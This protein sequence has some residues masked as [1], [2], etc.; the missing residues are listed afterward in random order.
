MSWNYCII[1]IFCVSVSESWP[2]ADPEPVLYGEV[3]SPQYPNPYPPNLQKQWDL[4]V[5]EGYQISLTFT[6]LDIEASV[7]CYYDS[8]TVLHDEKVLGKFCGQNSTDGHHPGHQPILSPSNKLTLVLQTDQ[9]NPERHQNIGFRAHYQ[10]IDI[11]E[12]SAP[13]PADGSGPLCSQICLN[14]LGSYICSCHHGYELRHDQRT[15][16]LSCVGGIFDDLEGHISS[17]GYPNAPPHAVSCQYIISV[18]QGFQ[19][20][21]NFSDNFN[22]ESMETEEGTSCHHHWLQ[23]TIENKE[24]MKLCGK[25]S[26]G[27][28][29][30]NSNIVKLDYYADAD[31]LSSGWS[32]E[33][34]TERVK[35]AGPGTVHKGRVTPILDE[36]FYRDYIFM[37]CDT[38]YKLMMEGEEIESFYAMCQSNGQWHL[39]LP[40]CHIIDCGE[41]EPLIN[42]GVI[43]LSG[44]LNQY[45]SVVQYYC[46]EPYYS[47][48]GSVNESFAC[49]ADRKWRAIN[50]VGLI[51]T[52]IPVCGKPTV[53]LPHFQRIIGGA[54][55]PDRSIPWQVRLL[56]NKNTGG[57]MVIADR[58]VLTAAHVLTAYDPVQN[59]QQPVSHDTVEIFWGTNA[60]EDNQV[61]NAKAA[62]IHIH[63]GYNNPDNLNFDNDIALIKLPE[64]IIFNAPVMPICL[65]SEGDIYEDEIIGLVSGFGLVLRDGKP[66]NLYK[67]KEL[68]YALLPVANPN[69]CN[70][71]L[72]RLRNTRGKI[73]TQ[74]ENMFCAGDSTGKKDSCQGDSGGPFALWKRD[75]FWAAGIVS[76]GVECGLPGTYGFYTR[77]A[78][79]VNWIQ[80]TMTEN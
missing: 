14:T 46:N 32:L 31:G 2:L 75:H 9:S 64:P 30:L 53:Q 13:E 34:T 39:A 69:K 6:H 22:I 5:L 4:R 12:C 3:Q 25:K 15:C 29:A 74:S 36:Y 23:V 44:V 63:P 1:W 35:C 65:P 21:L 76:W 8:L 70:S 11:D 45:G 27:L 66:G 72:S 58:W 26:P 68:T 42:G 49:E 20:F 18:Q 62:S 37:R 33:Y 17:P 59:S 28:M 41:P 51:P 67:S 40:E 16:V 48:L 77:V 7:D 55:A 10:A 79:Y 71:S 78:N 43:F 50:D 56:A 24:P 73:P 47:L 52:C 60:V 38:G 54:G 19:I 57:G 80:K 61:P